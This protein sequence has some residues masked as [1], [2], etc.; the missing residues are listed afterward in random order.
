MLIRFVAIGYIIRI[1]IAGIAED[2][3]IRWMFAW[4]WK[5]NDP[6]AMVKKCSLEH[7][8]REVIF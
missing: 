5:W 2:L 7:H 6:A 8:Y 3:R 1:Q 4:F